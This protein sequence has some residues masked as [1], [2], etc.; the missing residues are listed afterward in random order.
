MA[1]FN[2]IP[3]AL[4]YTISKYNKYIMLNEAKT[5][6]KIKFIYNK[7]SKLKDTLSHTYT[8]RYYVEQQEFVAG[9]YFGS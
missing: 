7:R 5:E 8:L 3:S 1:L 2:T 4:H 6:V 9:R